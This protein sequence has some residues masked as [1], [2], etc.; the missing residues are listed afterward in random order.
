ME[1][2]NDWVVDRNILANDIGNVAYSFFMNGKKKSFDFAMWLN[3]RKKLFVN[4]YRKYVKK[5]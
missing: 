1:Y 2:E 4:S 5:D 3:K